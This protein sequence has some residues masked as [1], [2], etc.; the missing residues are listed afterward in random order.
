LILLQPYPG[1]FK[2]LLI[3]KAG[4]NAFTFV[5][6]NVRQDNYNGGVAAILQSVMFQ[7]ELLQVFYQHGLQ[8]NCGM[9]TSAY[10]Y[11]SE[12]AVSFVRQRTVCRLC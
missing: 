4:D 1:S 11:D 6:F 9:D 12:T 10:I 3:E 8:I 7:P 5:S 2:K